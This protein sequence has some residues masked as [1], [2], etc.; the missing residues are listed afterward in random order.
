M[1]K[2]TTENTVEVGYDGLLALYAGENKILRG[3][4]ESLSGQVESLSEQ[5]KS[6]SGQLEWFKRQF[7]GQKSERLIDIPGDHPELPGFDVPVEAAEP[8]GKVDIPGHARRRNVSKGEDV[9]VIPED[10]ERVETVH[11]L[12]GDELV[13]PETGRTRVEIGR[14]VV[15]KLARRSGDFFV[16]RHVYVK[17]AVPGGALSGVVQAPAPAC[18]VEGS[19][20]DP[21]F[22]ADL[23]C[24]KYAFHMPLNRYQEKLAGFG[25]RVSRQT[26]S[27]LIVKLGAAVVP[28]YDLMI[29]E[30]FRQGVIFTDDTPVRLIVKG[31]GKTRQA[32]MWIYLAGKPNAPPYHIYDFT[33]DWKHSRPAEFLKNFKGTFHADAFEGYAKLDAA[34]EDVSWAACWAHAR[35]NF[36][37]ALGGGKP[38]FALKVLRIIRHLFLYERVAWNRTPAERLEIR[39]VK[40]RPLVEKLFGLLREKLSAADL[41][42]KSKLAG[43]IQYMLARRGNFELY[44]SNPDLRMDNNPAE[45]GLRKVVIG[46]KNWLFVGSSRAG[47]SAA[48]LISLVQTCR[49]MGINPRDYLEDVFTRLHDHPAK[50]LREFLPDQWT[51]P[52]KE[53]AKNRPH[54]PPR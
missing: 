49:A 35:R 17:Y 9:L 23:V 24:E 21:S 11:E 25:I 50:R 27:S 14:E 46:K 48:A 2:D 31:R 18:V 53:S 44:L 13:C 38:P 47:K 30:T 36:V 26:L 32:R 37:E 45:R 42:P 54:P 4:V 3:Q 39:D 12:G 5:V 34:R 52:E 16:V 22:M 10:L 1:M 29:R 51:P 28:L 40:E 8:V 19:K 15:E 7:F 41:L 20:F 43:A 6:L 33:E